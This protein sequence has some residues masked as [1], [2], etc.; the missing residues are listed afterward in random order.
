MLLLLVITALGGEPARR[1][2]ITIDDLPFVSAN[3]LSSE[4]LRVRTEAL[5]AHLRARAVPAIGFVN[6]GKIF[7]GGSEDPA[8]VSLLELWLQAGMELG[9]HSYSHLDFHETPLTEFQEDVLRGEPVIRRLLAARGEAPRFF[10]H[11]FLHTGREPR[12]K[13]AFEAFLAGRGYRVAPVTIDNHD[14]LFARA[15]DRAA[16]LEKK[17]V[18][19]SYLRYMLAVVEYYEAQSRAILGYELPQ[20]L[21]LHAN[22]LNADGLG[23]L[24]DRITERGYEF[25]SLEEALRDPAFSSEDTYTGPAGITWLHRWAMTRGV[26]KGTFSGE[27]EPAAFLPELK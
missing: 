16:E 10:R 25:V 27:P 17:R 6:E 26:P 13:A 15:Y 5:L 7:E 8:R 20:V 4:E 22:S 14:F 3:A 1:V 23:S 21:L 11:P 24:L 18:M 2:A 12:P 19:D 9:N